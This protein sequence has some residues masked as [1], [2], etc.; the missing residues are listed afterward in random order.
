MQSE[1]ATGRGHLKSLDG[2]VR[3]EEREEGEDVAI[4]IEFEDLMFVFFPSRVQ[5]SSDFFR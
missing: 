5:E 3:R 1:R 4:L 2:Y